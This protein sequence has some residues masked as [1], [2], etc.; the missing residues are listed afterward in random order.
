M[1]RMDG[2][3]TIFH[4]PLLL[5]PLLLFPVFLET[6]F[7]KRDEDVAE[8]PY[9]SRCECGCVDGKEPAPTQLWYLCALGSVASTT[10][11]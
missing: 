1:E 5:F 4:L 6:H 10:H 9:R 7:G 8:Q 2:P 11:Q 3:P